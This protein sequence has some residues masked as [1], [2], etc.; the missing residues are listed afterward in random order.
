MVTIRNSL[1]SVSR[2]AQPQRDSAPSQ[3]VSGVPASPAANQRTLALFRHPGKAASVGSRLS[4]GKRLSG[5]RIPLSPSMLADL[6]PEILYFQPPANQKR[7]LL[8]DLASFG[9][10]HP[11]PS[12][13]SSIVWKP[14]PTTTTQ[15]SA[16][17]S[18]AASDAALL[19]GC[20]PRPMPTLPGTR[21]QL[22][23]RSLRKRTRTIGLPD[24]PCDA[25]CEKSPPDASQNL[26][27]HAQLTETKELKTSSIIISHPP[28]RCVTRVDCLPYFGKHFK[29]TMA[30]DERR[31]TRIE[32]QILMD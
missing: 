7:K 20:P 30:A 19:T 23:L 8:Y 10:L 12:T 3:P 1:C 14:S 9:C 4:P 22:K 32:N 2:V 26:D 28:P 5:S 31:S 15:T 21:I 16:S 25:S 29:Q 6:H 13:L 11:P 24:H 27:P 17:P 18:G